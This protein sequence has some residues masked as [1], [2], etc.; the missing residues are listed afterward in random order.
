MNDYFTDPDVL[1]CQKLYLREALDWVAAEPQVFALEIYNEQNWNGRQFMFPVEDA[2]IRWSREIVKTIKKRLKRMPVTLSHPGFG[3]A[4]YEPFK[5]TKT[6]GVDFY[7]PHAYAGL[8]GENESIDF[9]AVTAAAGLIMNAGIPSFYGEWGLFNSPVPLEAKRFSHRDAIWLCLLGGEAGF[10]QWT[11]EFPEEYRW[12]SKVFKALPRNFSPQRPQTVVRIGREYAAFQDNTRYPAFKPGE[13]I[14]FDLNRQ[15]QRDPNLQKIFAAYT[16]SLET[17]VPIAFSL[18]EKGMTLDAFAA[19]DPARLKRPLWAG[20][21]CQ[22]TWLKDAHNPL[23]IGYVR[24]REIRGFGGQFAGVPKAGPLIIRF[25]LPRGKYVVRLIDLNTGK[26]ERRTLQSAGA[27][28]LAEGS[29]SVVIVTSES[30]KLAL[31]PA[32]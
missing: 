31:D 8:S 5:W 17:S 2:E 24:K 3:I 28:E 30:L 15:K 26:L 4:G 22:M 7:S 19:L 6:A 12:P 32:D 21:G 16:R 27:Y 13:F 14:G 18:S 23:W 25:D 10:Q 1:A 9:A 29:D 20:A 11:N